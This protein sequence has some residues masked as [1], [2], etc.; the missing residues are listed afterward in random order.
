M[1]G[2]ID[3]QK[4]FDVPD[5][6]TEDRTRGAEAVAALGT[7]GGMAAYLAPQAQR[8]AA[9][10]FGRMLGVDLRSEKEKIQEQLRQMGTPQT[11]AE[12]QAYAD[13]LDKLKTGAGLQYQMARAQEKRAERQ[14]AVN[15]GQ[16]QAQIARDEQSKLESNERMRI[17]A[18]TLVRN[19]D[20]DKKPQ[21]QRAGDR[22]VA[23]SFDEDNKPVVEEIYDGS[24]SLNADQ[25]A[26]LTQA[27]SLKYADNPE[28]FA[29]I[30]SNILSGNITDAGDF[31]DYVTLSEAPER[32]QMLG[33]MRTISEKNSDMSNDAL[34]SLN[35]IDIATNRMV[36]EGLL[37][38]DGSVNE[39]LRTAGGFAGRTLESFL[40]FTGQRDEFSKLRTAFAREKNQEI[41]NSLP[42]GVASDRDISIFAA[43]F[44]PEDA[45]LEEVAEYFEQA[46]Y[47]QEQLIDH[48]RLADAHWAKQMDRGENASNAGL[49]TAWQDF[50]Q[51]TERDYLGQE[52]A[53]I[54]GL[55]LTPEQKSAEKQQ[56]LAEFKEKYGI[57]PYRYR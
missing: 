14:L 31:D 1:A 42:P 44:P 57:L 25:V 52:M 36:A 9:A 16:L 47:V 18:M 50:K 10:G 55:E 5:T 24:G 30:T 22:V 20:N 12:H 11:E 7:R 15:E 8:N 23:V 19:L 40:N 54:D 32:G 17:D 35:R 27:A 34:A 37:N 56:A 21:I 28:G 41:I 6:A 33:T 29:A 49:A 48:A 43:G 39:R 4:L 3:I 46:R 13:L 2:M 45:P 53:R 51:A 26:S 38:E